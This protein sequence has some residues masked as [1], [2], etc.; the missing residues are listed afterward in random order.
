MRKII[1]SILLLLVVVILGGYYYT[2]VKV[3]EMIP[4]EL[5]KIEDALNKESQKNDYGFVYKF[6]SK[7]KREF[8]KTTGEIVL[9]V[10]NDNEFNKIGTKSLVLDANIYNGPFPIN[11]LQSFNFLP[12]L[13]SGVF[14]VDKDKNKFIKSDDKSPIMITAEASYDKS[15]NADIEGKPLSLDEFHFAKNWNVSWSKDDDLYKASGD[16]G[17][18]KIVL[19]DALL[20]I[21]GVDFDSDYKNE[22]NI[23][24]KIAINKVSLNLEQD[25][26]LDISNFN[27]SGNL[28][29]SSSELLLK[30]DEFVASKQGKTQK[31]W[32]A[33]DLNLS[34]DGNF[35]NWYE[36]NSYLDK[37]F[38][39]KNLTIKNDADQINLSLALNLKAKYEKYARRFNFS[40]M[41]NK[42]NLDLNFTKNILVKLVNGYNISN[43]NSADLSSNDL[44]RFIGFFIAKGILVEAGDSLKL[45]LQAIEDGFN[46]NGKE[47]SNLELINYLPF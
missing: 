9:N 42:L 18:M 3:E 35:T 30:S 19:D 43:P 45:N 24:S 13:L 8:F 47:I 4:Q 12:K 40:K 23:N 20:N 38:N 21:Y 11:N 22:N 39:L 25:T 2:G 34:A 28:S 46:L 15:Y 6:E 41:F 37:T 29:E 26:K 27:Y 17:D 10:T 31:I 7:L 1:L 16:L 44:D 5:S 14:S 36:N 33:S 32:D